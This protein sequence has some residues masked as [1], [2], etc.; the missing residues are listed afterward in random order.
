[1]GSWRLFNRDESCAT[2]HYWNSMTDVMISPSIQ[3]TREKPFTLEVKFPDFTLFKFLQGNT[4]S[5]HKIGLSDNEMI[6][7]IEKSVTEEDDKCQFAKYSDQNA[8]I[9]AA[10]NGHDSLDFTLTIEH[11]YNRCPPDHLENDFIVP[12]AFFENIIIS[13]I[14][15]AKTNDFDSGDYLFLT[16]V[17]QG[18][19]PQFGDSPWFQDDFNQD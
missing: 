18:T 14:R 7:E 2:F 10:L 1:M 9:T 8:T 11:G 17:R 12:M 3:V 5:V 16:D 15:K 6:K 13:L 19:W 4:Y